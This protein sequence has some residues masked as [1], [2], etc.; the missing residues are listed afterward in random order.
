[1]NPTDGAA[2]FDVSESGTLAYL[3]VGSYARQTDLVLVDRH[4]KETRAL[5]ASDRYHHPRLSPDGTR[6]SV[7]ILSANSLGD[8]WV[9]Q[10]GRLGG[11]RV[12][13]GG[14]RDFGAEWTRDGRELIYSSENP[15]FDLYRRVAD[16]SQPARPLLT[17]TY[18]RYTG[19]VSADG[20][21]FAYVQSVSGGVELWTVSLQAAPNAAR[22]FANGFNLA[23]PALS[24]DGRWIAYDSDESD[25]VEVFVQSFPDPSLKRWKASADHGSEPL[26]TRG[27]HELVYRNGDSVMTVSV[28][29]ESGRS[30]VPA[31]LFAGPYPD[32]P[33]WSRPRSYDVTPDGE[34]FLMTRLPGA[35]PP[36]QVEMVLNWFDELRTKVPR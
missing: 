6:I 2:A 9:F 20:R 36:P 19:T 28:D 32:N 7:D 21:R 35:L 29:P 16:A 25:R 26:W 10:V 5:P 24:P 17:G 30:G 13:A 11:I 14:G 22:Y 1:M 23:H 27:G 12:T 3:P 8:V 18:D 31:L 34:R 15:F 4:G 33:G